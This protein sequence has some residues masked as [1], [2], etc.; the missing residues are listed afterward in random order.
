VFAC[1]FQIV[2]DERFY[3][4]LFDVIHVQDDEGEKNAQWA[5]DKPHLFVMKPQR[6]GGGKELLNVQNLVRKFC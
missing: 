6:E 5:A 3:N 4:V 2:V 1:E